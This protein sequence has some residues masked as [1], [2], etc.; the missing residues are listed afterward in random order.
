M[1]KRTCSKDENHLGGGVASKLGRG[2]FCL[3]IFLLCGNEIKNSK[4]SSFKY[5]SLN[6]FDSL[7]VFLVINTLHFSGLLYYRLWVSKIVH[8]TSAQN[9][10]FV[11]TRKRSG[12]SSSKCH[13]ITFVVEVLHQLLGFSGGS[14][15][16]VG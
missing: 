1:A 15:I 16:R 12:N 6:S 13:Q 5:W 7:T 3:S 2:T 10:G 4:V 14:R 11:N 8:S 9:C